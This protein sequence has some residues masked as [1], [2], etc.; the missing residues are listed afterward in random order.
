ML[1]N[2]STQSPAQ[3]RPVRARLDLTLE[4][5]YLDAERVL[6]MVRTRG[7]DVERLE[8]LPPRQCHLW[9]RTRP[10][11][12]QLLRARLERLP[13]VTVEGGARWTPS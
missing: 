5:A 2:P 13:G 1:V 7:Y 11:E 12:L 6:S 8:L 4:H 9:V 3:Q 10:G